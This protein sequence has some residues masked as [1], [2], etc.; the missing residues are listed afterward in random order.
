MD[1]WR[2]PSIVWVAVPMDAYDR[3]LASRNPYDHIWSLIGLNVFPRASSPSTHFPHGPVPAPQGIWIHGSIATLSSTTSSAFPPHRA[4]LLNHLHDIIWR[5][6]RPARTP[7]RLLDYNCL[8]PTA[9]PPWWAPRGRRSSGAA[10]TP[11][12]F[13]CSCHFNSFGP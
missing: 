13:S 2:R 11:G 4:V 9:F 3:P 12:P 10:P 7:Y 8:P 5:W 1:A 6:R